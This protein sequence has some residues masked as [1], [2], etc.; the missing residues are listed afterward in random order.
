MHCP[1]DSVSDIFVMFALLLFSI[2]EIYVTTYGRVLVDIFDTWCGCFLS[3]SLVIVN[4]WHF[5]SLLYVAVYYTVI[6]FVPGNC[7]AVPFVE[8]CAFFKKFQQLV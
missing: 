5:V 6:V 7:F 3:A 4:K 8:I 1:F 2:A